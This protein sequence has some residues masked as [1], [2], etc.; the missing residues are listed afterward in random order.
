MAKI[1]GKGSFAGVPFLIEENQSIDGGRRLVKHEY[2]LRDEGLN[3]DLG[4]KARTYNVACLVIGDDHIKQAEKL[5]EALEKGRGELKHPYFKSIEVRVESYKANYSTAHQRVTRFD[6]TFVDNI[7]ENAPKLAK[8][9]QFS[10]LTEYNNAINALSNEFAEQIAEINEFVD[11]LVDNPFTQLVD[12]MVGFIENTFES[13]NSVVVG[14]GDIK[15]KAESMKNRMM[16]LIRVPSLLAKELQGLVQF[17]QYK[18]ISTK[19]G[20]N[21]RAIT[22]NVI[23]NTIYE[24]T[25]SKTDMPKAMVD[26]IVNA[27]RHNINATDILK[28]HATGLH[29]Q[30]I[31]QALMTKAQFSCVRLITS[32]LAVEYAK[33]VTEALTDSLSNDV[34]AIESKTD[35]KTFIGEI[36]SQLEQAILDNADAENWQSYQVLEQFRLAV[37]SDL[38]MRGE[39]LSHVKSV[40]LTDTFPALVVQ[41]QHS[42]KSQKWQQLVQRNAIT[43]PLFCIGGN[44]IEV[45]Q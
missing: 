42:G 37:I 13:I 33:S 20:L 34:Q 29:Q 31:T 1:T 44:E 6:I 26:V 3:E 8:N 28:R 19:Q 38:R 4:K 25:K 40:C 7:Q 5:I 24:T 41:Y 39:Q 14:V 43:H 2:P 15:T 30:E 16:N 18:G 22:T 35:I 9:T 45:L 32:T 10:V 27:K 36:D 11:L 23:H 21:Q 17:K 12:S